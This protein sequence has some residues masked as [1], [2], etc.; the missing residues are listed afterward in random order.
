MSKTTALRR[1]QARD[2]LRELCPVGSMV[3]TNLRSVSK[4]GMTREI[5]VHL[6][7]PGGGIRDVTQLVADAAGFNMS[8]TRYAL[9]VGGCGMDM[10]FHVVYSLGHALYPDGVRCTGSNGYTTK[11]NRSTIPACL[12]NDH[13]NDYG[14]LRRQYDAE[15]DGIHEGGREYVSD[16]QDWIRAQPTYTRKRTH[17]D[18]GYALK[19]NWI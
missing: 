11:S 4:S 12:S 2:I 10:G 8:P 6:A 15:H 5:S 9:K 18:G 16:R 3:Y 1:E 19:Q 13:V 14:D 7:Q 17:R